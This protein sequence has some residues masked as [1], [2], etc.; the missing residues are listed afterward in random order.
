MKKTSF[1]VAL[2]FT[3]AAALC[4]FAAD[5]PKDGKAAKASVAEKAK[6]SPPQAPK[7]E[8]KVL[9][10]G[11]YIK[12]DVHRSGLITNG[13]DQVLVI[14]SDMIARSGAADLKQV[15]VHQGIH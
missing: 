1:V 4:A 11:S 10:T 13:K 8:D 9:I 7:Q 6:I 3:L 15:L 2:A 14:D 5:P 12:R